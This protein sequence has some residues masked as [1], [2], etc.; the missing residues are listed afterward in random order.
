MYL[1]GNFSLLEL[2]IVNDYSL[3]VFVINII[4]LKLAWFILNKNKEHEKQYCFNGL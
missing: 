4:Y 3:K 1:L 2:K